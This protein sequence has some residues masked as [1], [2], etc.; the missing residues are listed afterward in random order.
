MITTRKAQ[1]LDVV[2]ILEDLPEFGVR[3]GERGAVVEVF[4]EPE[5][6]Y[7]IEFVDESRKNSPGRLGEARS[8]CD[9]AFKIR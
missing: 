1:L 6:A 2:E 7:I 4:D 3:R 8:D 9:S 5:E